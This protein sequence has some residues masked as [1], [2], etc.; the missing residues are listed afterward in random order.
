MGGRQHVL[1]HPE[2]TQAKV[3]INKA[4]YT[5]SKIHAWHE[6]L[7]LAALKFDF[8]NRIE[9]YPN[10]KLSLDIPNVGDDVLA[11]GSPA[12]GGLNSMTKGIVSNFAFRPD[13]ELLFI[14][15]DAAI[16]PG[17][18][19]GPLLNMSG[20]VIGVNTIRPERTASG[21]II[22]GIGYAIPA[23]D[24]Q[25]LLFN[26]NRINFGELPPLS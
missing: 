3:I 11:I 18:S 20:D 22:I 26:N 23:R 16:N 19:G 13:G 7:D 25:S 2:A 9:G 14:Q 17:N 1:D 24:I 4:V 15:T 8:P 6:T 12:Y 21:R 10:L 5:V